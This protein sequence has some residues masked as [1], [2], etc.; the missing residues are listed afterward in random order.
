MVSATQIKQLRDHTG[1]GFQD[2]R[3]ALLENEGDFGRAVA[4]LRQQGIT[5]AAKKA[6]RAANEG[7]VEVY[8]HHNGRLSVMVEVNCETDF[9][10]RSDPFR[11]FARDLALHVANSTPS[12][13]KRDDILLAE[14]NAQRAKLHEKTLSEG[15]TGALVDKIVAGRMEK[16]YKEIVLMEQVWLHDDQHT[17]NEALTQ[18]IA[19][20]K[21][22]VVIRRFALF[23]LSESAEVE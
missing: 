9:V 15:K 13:V 20:V 10:A 21:E 14:I 22:N 6:A 4:S 12:Y 19:V 16:W 11:K 2:C 23:A 18:L 8:R 3:R 7:V 17:V 5:T 1:A